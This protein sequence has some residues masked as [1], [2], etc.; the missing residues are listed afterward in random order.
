MLY[1]VWTGLLTLAQVR[2][3]CSA[4]AGSVEQRLAMRASLLAASQR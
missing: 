3:L 1:T 4:L 2:L